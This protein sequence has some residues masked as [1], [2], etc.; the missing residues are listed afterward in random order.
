M[1]LMSSF[2]P[3]SGPVPQPS[4]EQPPAS[5]KLDYKLSQAS[6][7]RAS[8]PV[9]PSPLAPKSRTV[10]FFEGIC[11]SAGSAARVRSAANRVMATRT[12]RREPCR[13]QFMRTTVTTA[14]DNK[15][16]RRDARISSILFA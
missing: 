3:V 8:E 15:R 10:K 4:T 1:L 14:A 2:G 12:R 6:T 7:R 11:G 5:P 16:L 13:A 9:V